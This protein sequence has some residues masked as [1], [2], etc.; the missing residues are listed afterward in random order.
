MAKL[1]LDEKLKEK[2][3]KRTQGE[4]INDNTLKIFA[5]GYV[6]PCN[7]FFKQS[8]VHGMNVIL[9][10]L[11]FDVSFYSNLRSDFALHSF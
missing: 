2:R 5:L 3:G 4:K 6:K 7:G 1:E 8:F 10:D 9:S 11:Y